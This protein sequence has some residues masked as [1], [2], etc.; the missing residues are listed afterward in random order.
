MHTYIFRTYIDGGRE[1][2]EYTDAADREQTI[3]KD[4]PFPESLMSLLYM[5]IWE[6]SHHQEDGQGLAGFLPV[7]RQG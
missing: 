2:Y 3:K 7:Q 5:D 6:L 4:F 1:Y